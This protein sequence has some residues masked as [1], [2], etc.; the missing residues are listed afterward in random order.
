M[1]LSCQGGNPITYFTLTLPG[2][3]DELQEG[4]RRGD[5][6]DLM[7][8]PE[9]DTI[10]TNPGFAESNLHKRRCCPAPAAMLTELVD[11]ARRRFLWNEIL[12]QGAWAVSAG[13]GAV[14]LL[15]LLGTEI[16]E[17]YWLLLLPAATLA[18]GVWRTLRRVPSRYA[19]A[20]L[21][22]ARLGL[23]DTISTALY[24]SRPSCAASVSGEVREAQR[25][26]AEGLA[27][28]VDPRA[29]VPF[30]MP[31]AVYSMAALAVAA[32]SLFALRYGLEHRLDLQRPLASVIRQALGLEEQQ[33]AALD[34]KKDDPRQKRTEANRLPGLAINE[35]NLPGELQAATAA[36]LDNADAAQ[37]PAEQ[38]TARQGNQDVQGLSL[39]EDSEGGEGEAAEG[40]EASEGEQGEAGQQGSANGQ[41]KASPNQSAGNQ[42]NNSSLM[43]K[44]RDAMQNLMSRMRQQPSGRHG[45]AAAGRAGPELPAGAEGRARAGR[46]S[47]ASSSA[48]GRRR[49]A[50][51][52]SRARSRRRRRMPAAA[53]QSNGGEE[54]STQAARQRHRAAGR[55]QGRE[56]RRTAR[57]HGQDQRDHRQAFGQ[58]QRRSDGGGAVQ[59]PAV[60]DAVLAA[61][62]THGEAATEISRDEVPVALAGLRAAVLRAGA[63]AAGEVKSKRHPE[64]TIPL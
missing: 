39:G 27:R 58:R 17:W 13:M 9:N 8:L 46:L 10:E 3:E 61:R 5:A 24:F 59:Q 45:G 29:A 37:A 20:Q 38:N 4:M 22:D 14:I 42:G 63:E 50:G 15:L 36:S 32:T 21:I 55:R 7:T 62:G 6:P 53:G 51:R 44:F 12:A 25:A 16:L 31:H 11:R 26:R 41:Q 49:R 30:T 56:T 60:A 48:A 18:A 28:G 43:A 57:R 23:S 19:I 52:A 54:Q 47:R 40:M 34:K 1:V 35:T 2:S 64:T 33:L